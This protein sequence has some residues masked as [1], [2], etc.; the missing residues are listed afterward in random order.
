[1]DPIKEFDLYPEAEKWRIIDELILR[2]TKI[3]YGNVFFRIVPDLH[4]GERKVDTREMRETFK[5][6]QE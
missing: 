4:T 5:D 1:M 2:T 6:W 3:R